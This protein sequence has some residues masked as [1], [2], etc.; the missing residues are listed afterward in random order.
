MD[1]VLMRI[2]GNRT[3]SRWHCIEPNLISAPQEPDSRTCLFSVIDSQYS[4]QAVLVHSLLLFILKQ[5]P[6]SP[7]WAREPQFGCRKKSAES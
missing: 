5:I 2:Q 4:Q 6:L 3:K 1:N 7:A